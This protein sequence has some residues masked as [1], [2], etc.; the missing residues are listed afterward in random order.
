M[1]GEEDEEED[2]DAG[3]GW[4][5]GEG[6]RGVYCQG[7]WWCAMGSG[8]SRGGDQPRAGTGNAD[9]GPMSGAGPAFYRVWQCPLLH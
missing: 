5:E 6:G 3:D 9:L 7:V 8:V 4:V 2:D 1:L